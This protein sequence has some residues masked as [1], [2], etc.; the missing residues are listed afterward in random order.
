MRRGLL[1]L[2]AIVCALAAV[3]PASAI[4]GLP[5][6][7]KGRTKA[8]GALIDSYVKD[9]FL[10]EN[11]AAGWRLSG[12]QMR[13]GMTRKEW[14]TGRLLPVQR[15]NV[16]G[17]RWDHAWN[18]TYV[19]HNEIGLS[20]TLRVG[21]GNNAEMYD[22]EMVLAR[23]GKIWVVNGT[24]TNAVFRLGHHEGS[25]VSDK[26]ATTGL[27]DFKAGSGAGNPTAPAQLGHFWLFLVIGTVVGIPL[28]ALV[29]YLFYIRSRNRRAWAAH[30][31]TPSA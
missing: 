8:V 27:N 24:Y 19:G 20:L 29:S 9:V 23:R 15:F 4:P 26:C 25:C 10:R 11:L 22:Q 18:V 31:G 14:L 16:V 1:A 21:K 30:V 3:A 13:A 7:G 17:S 5:K 2:L 28:T 12:P 6:L